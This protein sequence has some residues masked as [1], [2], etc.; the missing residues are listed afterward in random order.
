MRRSYLQWEE[1]VESA[2]ERKDL[3][4]YF[5]Q[6]MR[7]GVLYWSRP[8]ETVPKQASNACRV[9]PDM[10]QRGARREIHQI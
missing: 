9:Y 4:K 7:G 2:N 8:K 5:M 10:G 1:A 3:D 6:E